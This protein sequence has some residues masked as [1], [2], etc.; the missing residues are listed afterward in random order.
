MSTPVHPGAE[1]AVRALIPDVAALTRRLDAVD[2][3]ADEG[4]ATALFF[5]LRLP[6]PLL[7]LRKHPARLAHVRAACVPQPSLRESVLVEGAASSYHIGA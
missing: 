3:L 1:D 7:G 2:Y 5:A 6:Q 4:L